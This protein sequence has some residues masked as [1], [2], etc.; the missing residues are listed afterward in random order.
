MPTMLQLEEFD[1]ASAQ[2]FVSGAP[3]PFSATIGGDDESA[4]NN[5]FEQGYKAG[6][7]DASQASASDQSKISAEFSRNLQDLGFTFFEARSHVMR[8]LEP[9]LSAM[10]DTLLP[11]LVSASMG[12]RIAEELLPLAETAADT[13]IEIVVSPASRAA[14]EPL[15]AAATTVPLT[16]SEE[17]SLGEGQV[18]LR[19]G[20]MEKQIDLGGAVQR[21]SEVILAMSQD[22]EKVFRHG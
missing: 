16:L 7:D 19:S 18:H 21:V 12:Q 11:E 20:K 8:S 9:L 3:S 2:G 4:G 17:P 15:L 14:L 1:A 13:P 22:N 10:A 5:S 6:W